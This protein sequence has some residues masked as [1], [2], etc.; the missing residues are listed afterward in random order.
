MFF[1]L[2]FSLLRSSYRAPQKF[3]G[4]FPEIP[5][6]SVTMPTGNSGLTGNSGNKSEQT[7]SHV[8]LASC[9]ESHSEAEMKHAGAPKN[10]AVEHSDCGGHQ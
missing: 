7:I 4:D 3:G 2:K 9:D 8:L 5:H 10:E 1:S 6:A